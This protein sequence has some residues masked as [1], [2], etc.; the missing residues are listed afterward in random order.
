M[1]SKFVDKP[2]MFQ[3]LVSTRVALNKGDARSQGAG[4]I[5]KRLSFRRKPFGAANVIDK[6]TEHRM[7]LAR[8]VQNDLRAELEALEPLAKNSSKDQQTPG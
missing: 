5:F 7:N 1:S 3:D 2:P 4:K 8:N 6:L